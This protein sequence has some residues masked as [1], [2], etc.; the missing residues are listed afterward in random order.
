V[1]AGT[2]WG[3][4]RGWAGV[5]SSHL[6]HTGATHIEAHASAESGLEV[7]IF[8]ILNAGKALCQLSLFVATLMMMMQDDASVKL[9]PPKLPR[10]SVSQLHPIYCQNDDAISI[11][12]IEL[13]AT[14]FTF[15]TL[16]KR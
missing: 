3:L 12:R 10:S 4:G 9:G 13:P 14:L 5:S 2:G 11:T 7:G 16:G 1:Q 8:D 15:V 6:Q